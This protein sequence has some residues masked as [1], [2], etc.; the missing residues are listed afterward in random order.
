[1]YEFI[2]KYKEI[3]TRV[4]I[5]STVKFMKVYVDDLNQGV[6]LLPYGTIY[7]DGKLY[8]PGMGWTGRSFKGKAM[9]KEEREQI[10]NRAEEANRQE[11]T[12]VEKEKYSAKIFREI[13]NTC[14]PRSIRMVEDLPGNHETGYLPILDTVMKVEGGQIRFIHYSK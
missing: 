13:A 10:E 11:H 5:C 6:S 14:K 8:R 2:K 4:E 12:Q 9:T 1:M 3:L 7:V